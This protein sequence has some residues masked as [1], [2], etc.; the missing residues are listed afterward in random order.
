MG[1]TDWSR[2]IKVY[3]SF[4]R[5]KFHFLSVIWFVFLILLLPGCSTK[6][7]VTDD[8]Y[9]QYKGQ[10]NQHT[11]LISA[12]ARRIFGILTREDM[13]KSVCPQGTL[14]THKPPLPYQ[15]GTVVETKVDHIFK[16]KWRSQVVALVPDQKIRLQFLSG[17]FAGG[18][19]I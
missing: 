13:F 16:L 8:K 2:V 19:E 4:F 9:A 18:T 10:V 1:K 6:Y 7:I 5:L 11:R 17:F 14:V 15:V 3:L 12:D